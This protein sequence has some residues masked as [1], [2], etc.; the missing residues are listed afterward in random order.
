MPP[1]TVADISPANIKF[2][3]IIFAFK[4]GIMPRILLLYDHGDV[5]MLNS[6]VSYPK[7][8]LR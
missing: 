8:S 2:F 4:R 5:A 1:K 7:E 6:S 3:S